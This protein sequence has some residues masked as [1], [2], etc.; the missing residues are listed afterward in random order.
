MISKEIWAL[1]IKTGQVKKYDSMTNCINTLNLKYIH[2]SDVLDPYLVET[3]PLLK[4]LN[5][6]IIIRPNS[7]PV[8]M[9]RAYDYARSNRAIPAKEKSTITITRPSDGLTRTYDSYPKASQ[10]LK[11]DFGVHKG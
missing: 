10:G 8:I 11:D 9:E 5:G 3:E 1:S 2:P 4:S 6:Y 7:D